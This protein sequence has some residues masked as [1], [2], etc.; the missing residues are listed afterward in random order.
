ML[1]DG[2]DELRWLIAYAY[3]YHRGLVDRSR[4][5]PIII[6]DRGGTVQ[7]L[8]AIDEDARGEDQEEAL[9]T[10]R[11]WAKVVADFLGP[12]GTGVIAQQARWRQRMSKRETSY[13]KL[14]KELNAQ[15][16]DLVRQ[17]V[18]AADGIAECNE[19]LAATSRRILDL[20]GRNLSDADELAAMRRVLAVHGD[21]QFDA[22]D[23]RW[24][25]G[26]QQRAVREE[27][28][29]LLRAGGYAR[30]RI[31]PTIEG[32]ARRVRNGEAPFEEDKPF[33]RDQIIDSLRSEHKSRKA[34]E[35]RLKAVQRRRPLEKV[36]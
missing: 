30:A 7:A 29:L 3:R 5:L 15:A 8:L 36:A 13:R 19:I 4:E 26:N 23:R 22:L 34:K 14:A 17:E 24:D 6:T 18:A 33:T 27:L 31:Q 16:A 10:A 20:Q 9:R 21:D 25:L 32:A 12:D 1:I 35:A 11:E 28:R 2:S